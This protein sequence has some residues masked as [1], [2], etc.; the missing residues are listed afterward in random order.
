MRASDLISMDTGIPNGSKDQNYSHKQVTSIV[1]GSCI[2][3]RQGNITSG[4]S[5]YNSPFYGGE[6]ITNRVY[7][8][9]SDTF[10]SSDSP[11]SVPR[12][13]SCFRISSRRCNIGG[14]K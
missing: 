8:Y 3:I 9:K 11:A 12:A 13:K 4:S 7:D 5:K 6:H 10:M 2:G 14:M 1:A